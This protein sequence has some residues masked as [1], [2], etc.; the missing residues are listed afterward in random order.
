MGSLRWILSELPRFVRT[1]AAAV[2]L[3]LSPRILEKHRIEGTGPIYRKLGGRVVYA[4]EDLD[5]WAALVVQSRSE[6]GG[7]VPETVWLVCPSLTDRL[8]GC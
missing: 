8:I 1:P 7:I 4:I 3:G 6:V 2:L 5:A